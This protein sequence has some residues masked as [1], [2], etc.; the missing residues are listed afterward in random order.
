MMFNLL[1]QLAD[2]LAAFYRDLGSR[3]RDPGITVVTM[4]EFGRRVAQ[5]AGHG[6]DHGRGNC[7]FL[8]GNGVVSGVHAQWPGLEPGDLVD[9][10]LAVTID[11]RDILAELLARRLNNA[12]VSQVFPG[13]AVRMHDVFRTRAGTVAPTPVPPAMPTAVP[14]DQRATVFLPWVGR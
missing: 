5:N 10:D 1:K 2:G 8:L 14:T 11:Y 13:H 12:A 4:S 9:G 3:F 6:T 7:M